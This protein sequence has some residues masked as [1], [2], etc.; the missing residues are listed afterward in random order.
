MDMLKT[1]ESLIVC[2]VNLV[3]FKFKLRILINMVVLEIEVNTKFGIILEDFFK[4]LIDIYYRYYR[5]L[6][7]ERV[8]AVGQGQKERETSRHPRVGSPILGP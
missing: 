6:L 3:S 4:R 1:T 7:R 2:D 5:Y 8:Q